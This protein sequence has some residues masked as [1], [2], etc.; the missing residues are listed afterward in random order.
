M[1]LTSE[2]FTCRWDARQLLSR[3]QR[4]EWLARSPLALFLRGKCT[5]GIRETL[6]HVPGRTA[7]PYAAESSPDDC[8][9]TALTTGPQSQL[10]R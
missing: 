1:K 4:P 7:A 6:A 3:L 10:E 5:H 2:A 9:A 8:L